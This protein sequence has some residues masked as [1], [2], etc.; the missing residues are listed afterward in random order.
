[1]ATSQFASRLKMLRDVA[2][3][4]LRNL[5]EELGVT[6]STISR[7]EREETTPKR[8]DVEKLD[9]VLGAQGKLLR[10]WTSQ[11]SGSTL[12]PWM[13]DTAR[14]MAEAVTIEYFSPVLVP[15]MLQC[16]EYAEM[17]FRHGQPLEPVEEVQR[18]AMARSSRYEQLRHGR[19][20][21]IS[22]VFP[23]SALT[24]VPEGPRKA[25]AAHLCGIV[26]T[27]RVTVCLVP[28][29]TLLVGI[30][31]P[32]LMVR[33]ADGG[34]AAASDH[35]VG[36]VLLDEESTDWARLDQLAKQAFAVALPSHQSRNLLG[37][38]Q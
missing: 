21:Q 31:S 14:L 25:Q 38:M 22:A 3:L 6:A 13:Q 18:L 4:T 8:D 36:N 5:A 33:L 24:C 29:G 2:G 9:A 10:L 17:V 11:T 16:P 20:P 23:M 34:R 12:P 37:D 26:D 35:I 19:D 1:M 30:T 28:E 7:W 15:G 27:S 32:L